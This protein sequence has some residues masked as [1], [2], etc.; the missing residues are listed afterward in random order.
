MSIIA[1][2]VEGKITWSQAETQIEG[3]F[4]GIL[5]SNPAIA[6][7]VAAAQ[8][9]LKQVAS[10]ALGLADTALGPIISAGALSVEGAATV[11]LTA[12]GVGFDLNA[13]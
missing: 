11:A 13:G 10:D 7:D 4:K 5:S 8:S 9:D 2:L 6:T 12:A 1:Q 3:W